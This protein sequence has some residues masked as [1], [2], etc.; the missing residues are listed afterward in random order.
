ML[1]PPNSIL[2][3][4]DNDAERYYLTRILGKAGFRVLEAATG[5]DG[6]RLAEAERPDVVTLD[7]RLPDLNGYEVCRRLKSQ[8]ATRDIQVLH[9]SASF[10]TPDA[11]AEGLDSG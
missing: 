9:I 6:L 1:E 2:V 8:P 11:K 3:I 5:L 10:T 7:I 4:D